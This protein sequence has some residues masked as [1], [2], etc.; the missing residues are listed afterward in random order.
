MG[1][2]EYDSLVAEGRYFAQDNQLSWH[3]PINDDGDVPKQFRWNLS[4]VISAP[5]PPVFWLSTARVPSSAERAL[6][7]IYSSRQYTI[8]SKLWLTDEWW[9]LYKAIALHTLLVR[10]NKLPHVSVNILKI[11]RILGVCCFPHTPWE[12]S[13]EDTRKA[14]NVSLLIGASG[15][16]ALNMEMVIRLFLDGMHLTDARPLSQY[17]QPFQ[18][19]R[20]QQGKVD[21]RRKSERTF[22]HTDLVRKNLSDRK[23]ADRLPDKQA[24]WELVDIIFTEQPRTFSDFIRFRVIQLCILTGLRIGEIVSLP[25]DC[26]RKRTY[27]TKDGEPAEAEHGI[28]TSLT[29]RY[30][31]EKNVTQFSKSSLILTENTQHVPPMF[32]D[33]VEE[34]VE[35]TLLAT[36]AMRVRLEQQTTQKC[37]FP[38]LHHNKFVPSYEAYT[39]VTGSITITNCGVPP[40]MIEEYREEYNPSLLDK[41]YQ[42]QVREIEHN[43]QKLSSNIRR[44]HHLWKNNVGAYTRGGRKISGRLG[45]KGI[46]FKVSQIEAFLNEFRPNKRPDVA[47]VKLQNGQFHFPHQNLFLVPTHAVSEGRHGNVTNSN[48]YYSVSKASTQDVMRMLDGSSKDSIFARY[49]PQIAENLFL[50][51]HSIRHLQNTELMR[52]NVADTVVSKRFRKDVRHATAYDHRSLLEDLKNIAID[53]EFASLLSERGQTIYKMVKTGKLSGSIVDEFRQIEMSEGTKVAVQYIQ[54]EADGFHVTPYGLC[55]NAFTIETCPKHLECFN[56]CKHLARTNV[57]SEEDNLKKL[58][59]RLAEWIGVIENQPIQNRPFGW[60]NQLDHT[61]DRLD[62]VDKALATKPGLRVFP[63]GHDRYEGHCGSKPTILDT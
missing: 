17:C 22:R 57:Q 18:E 63:D 48:L 38:E 52:L 19:Y 56:N 33:I 11:I 15:K 40:G 25:A 16:T 54:S 35:S 31:S 20:A 55:L 32:S 4:R 29:L 14:Y 58:R 7:T 34:I 24:F 27:S 61:R 1:K 39:R 5:T 6:K 44:F 30:F 42:F 36:S 12:V 59:S 23:S 2:T 26:L 3:V 10:K 43:D 53:D 37:L 50:R 9:D 51:T 46:Y 28:T 21:A 8:P 49:R 60:K 45:W 41:I 13:S 47:P 62:A